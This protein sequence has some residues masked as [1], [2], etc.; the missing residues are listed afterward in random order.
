[1][2]VFKQPGKLLYQFEKSKKPEHIP[3]IY[4]M[5]NLN[6]IYVHN[7]YINDIFWRLSQTARAK[8]K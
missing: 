5:Q 4:M 3:K 8:S 6:H 1:M 7:H 2:G